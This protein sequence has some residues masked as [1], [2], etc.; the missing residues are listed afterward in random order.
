V[1]AISQAVLYRPD[2]KTQRTVRLDAKV[3][4][5]FKTCWKT[6]ATMVTTRTFEDAR[7]FATAIRVSTSQSNR[8]EPRRM[9]FQQDTIACASR[10][11]IPKRRGLELRLAINGP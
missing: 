8:D 4:A 6:I 5:P 1:V 9:A 10:I 3:G 11:C 7:A 2:H